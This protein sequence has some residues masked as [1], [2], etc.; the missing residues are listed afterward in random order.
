MRKSEKIK[1]AL[2]MCAT[3][4]LITQHP[5][6]LKKG[7]GIH[8]KGSLMK[9]WLVHEIRLKLRGRFFF[10]KNYNYFIKI[11]TDIIN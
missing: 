5:G 8:F 11:N 2:H 9:V 4:G 6:N 1:F 10:V 7:K 3:N